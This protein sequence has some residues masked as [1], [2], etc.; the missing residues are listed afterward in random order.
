MERDELKQTLQNQ[1]N[2]RT[3]KGVGVGCAV[4]ADGNGGAEKSWEVY[5][6]VE[7]G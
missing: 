3:G 6:D 4:H 1:G 7:N 5:E 2:V